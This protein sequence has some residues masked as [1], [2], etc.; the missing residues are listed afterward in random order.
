VN[1]NKG[2]EMKNKSVVSYALLE[3]EGCL[4]IGSVNELISLDIAELKEIGEQ[5]LKLIE[6]IEKASPRYGQ[7]LY[8][9]GGE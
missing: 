3:I 9:E 5:A 4:S 7:V 1:T 6:L 2:A 8:N